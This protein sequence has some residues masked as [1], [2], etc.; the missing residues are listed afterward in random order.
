MTA[1]Q[2]RKKSSDLLTVAEEDRSGSRASDRRSSQFSEHAEP[3]TTQEMM[4]ARAVT[5]AA[6]AGRFGFSD[7]GSGGS[8]LLSID[9]KHQPFFREGST[10]EKAALEDWLV[11]DEKSDRLAVLQR[12]IAFVSSF[13]CGRALCGNNSRVRRWAERHRVCTF[14]IVVSFAYVLCSIVLAAALSAVVDSVFP[15]RRRDLP[16]DVLQPAA[17]RGHPAPRA[18]LPRRRATLTSFRPPPPPG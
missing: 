11:G 13:W 12:L 5:M 6:A 9:W 8:K 3:L 17:R 16:H 4:R 2:L 7:E 14:V 10:G 18:R 15:A 1:I